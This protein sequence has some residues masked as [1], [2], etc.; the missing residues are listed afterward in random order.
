MQYGACVVTSSL[1][2]TYVI[3]L[4]SF[5]GRAIANI[6]GERSTH[7]ARTVALAGLYYSAGSDYDY[8]LRLVSDSPVL[9]LPSLPSDITSSGKGNKARSDSTH[10]TVGNQTLLNADTVGTVLSVYSAW[11]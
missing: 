3:I 9:V 10:H 1:S 11:R 2:C 4:Y 5:T 7:P 8:G 6:K